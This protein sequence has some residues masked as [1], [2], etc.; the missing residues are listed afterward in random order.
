MANPLISMVCCFSKNVTDNTNKI[1]GIIDDVE[2]FNFVL[3]D[4]Q[5]KDIL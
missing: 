5:D 3:D 4:I 1:L 2:S